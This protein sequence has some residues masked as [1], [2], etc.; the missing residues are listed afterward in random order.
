ME[1][2]PGVVHYLPIATTALAI[3]FAI[4]LFR[5]YAR[6]PD[7]LH[8]LWWAIGVTAYG[9]GTALESAVTLFGWS[10][11]LFKSWYVAGA[12]LGGAPLAQGTVYLLFSRRSAHV[13]TAL[14]VLVVAVAA[15]FVWLSP[16]NAALVEGHRLSGQ[17]MEWTWVRRFSPFINIYAFLFLV[18]GAI[19]SAMRY[20]GDPNTRHRAF[21][22]A[23]IAVGAIL[24]GIGG[25][26]TRMGYTEVLYVT[27]LVGLTLIWW[28]YRLNV[29]GPR[30]APEPSRRVRVS[31]TAS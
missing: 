30:P 13:L 27:E 10:P 12:L 19:W 9:I 22:N 2:G 1:S 21:G 15:V 16:I 26:A 29:R 5:H 31:P 3:P 7:G 20:A 6:K 17:V 23:L 28:G 11:F 4:A 25:S 18:G 24:P 8:L 14:L